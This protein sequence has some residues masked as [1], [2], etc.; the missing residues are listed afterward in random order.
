MMSSNRK[1]AISLLVIL[2]TLYSV[3][4]PAGGLG[5]QAAA[6]AETPGIQVAV[7]QAGYSKEDMKLGSVVSGRLLQDETFAVTAGGST[8]VFTGTL[9]Y[10]GLIWGGHVYTADFTGLKQTG[11][12]FRLVSGGVQ[13]PSFPIEDN[14][15]L[16]YRD[17]MTAFYRS[18]RASV[19]TADAL[20][21]GYT[22]TPLSPKAYHEAGHLDD[23]WDKNDVFAQYDITLLDGTRPAPGQHYD[24]TGGHYDAGDYGKYGGNQWVG[25]Q[26]ALAYLRY[27]EAEAVQFDY[28]D[29]GVPDILD[30]VRVAVEYT[31][32]FTDQ[33][34]GALFEIPE[35]GGF[36]HP[37]RM[38]DNIPLSPA[39]NSD[40]RTLGRLSIGGSAKAAG[41]MAAAARAY[42]AWLDEYG[43]ADAD[44]AAFAARAAAGA[45]KTYEYAYINHDK[46]HGG[47]HTGGDTTNPL[48]WAEVELYLLTGEQVYYDRAVQRI[49]VLE[50][51]DVGSTNYWSVRPIAMAE[52]Y[53]AADTATQSHIKRL[54]KSRV[55]Y[56]MS[57]AEDTPYGVLNEFSNFGVNEPHISYVGDLVRYYELFGDPEVLS[58]AKKGLF[59]VFGNNPW[60]TSWVSGVGENHVNYL[61]SRY[62]TEIRDPNNKGIVIPGAMV[63]GPNVK[64]PTVQTSVSGPWYEDR[65][66]IQDDVHQWRYN[67]FSISIQAGLFYSIMALG[68]LDEP[69]VPAAEEAELSILSPQIGDLVTGDVQVIAAAGPGVS[70]VKL[71][72]VAMT[73]SDG[74]WTASVNVDAARPYANGR[75]RATAAGSGGTT[76]SNSHYTVAPPLPSPQSPL[77]YDDFGGGGIWGA[78]NLAWMNWW[79]QDS[80][81]ANKTDGKFAKQTVDG[82]TVGVFTHEPSSPQALAKFQPWHYKAD[83][84]GYRYLYI[85]LKNS[86]RHPGLQFK[87]QINARDVNGS[88]MTVPNEWTTLQIDLNQVPNLDKSAVEL[89]FWLRGGARAGDVLIDNIQAGNE[90]S[91]SAPV[92]S[93]AEVHALTGDE[94]TVFHYSV[95]YTDADNDLPHDVQLVIDGVIHFMLEA[96][97]TD[98]DTSD[99]KRYILS[100]ALVRG[101]HQFYVRTTDTHTSVVQTPVQTGPVVAAAAP[102]AG[103]PAAP[104]NLRIVSATDASAVLEWTAPQDDRELTGYNIYQE[105]VLIGA[106]AKE[107]VRYEVTGLQQLT[108]YSFRVTAQGTA[109]ESAASNPV[110]LTTPETVLMPVRFLGQ[111]AVGANER[112]TAS[113]WPGSAQMTPQGWGKIWQSAQPMKWT[114]HFPETGVYDFSLRAYG[115]G[116]ATSARI[117]IDGQNVPDAAW[118]LGRAWTDYEGCLGTVTAGLHTV[119]IANTSTASNNNADIAHLDIFGAAPGAFALSAPADGAALEGTA[120]LLDWTQSIGGRAFA[121]F[122]ADEYT[123][124]VAGNE[125]FANPPV[126]AT[127]N[128]TTYEAGG[129]KSHTVYYWRVTAHNANRSTV[130]ETFSFT[131]AGAPGE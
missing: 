20:P 44:A 75:L 42:S 123:V 114:V 86:G 67:E 112:K 126:Q 72:D 93:G 103:V 46:E 82:R 16:Q 77:L 10:E 54:L 80:N 74:V 81:P 18:L 99:G 26:L 63:S 68:A 22:N 5:G 48:L 96:D 66:I 1:P 35:K 83:L 90:T 59:W 124:E 62:D 45:V 29:N 102:P 111:F 58:A 97:S 57:V 125:D 32:K 56:F 53:P 4:V 115:E 36:D 41:V 50:E 85:T 127:V 3:L 38:T 52:F 130:S 43:A 39:G 37:E 120:A 87:T 51:S 30:E 104:G 128:G 71:G 94:R 109:Q 13:S 31:L 92:L 129:L 95:T 78:Q 98:R 107:A 113:D 105:G 108:G 28:D 7:S 61:H 6:A 106:A 40:D 23:A 89:T 131:T 12:A 33:F 14:I 24:L 101:P 76:A 49:A 65:T 100:A 69:S 73:E 17:E 122:G 88:L 2:F 60:N 79:T 11:E 27:S 25:G 47:Y 70:G 118:T 91:G 8:P 117:R 64:D 119:E 19:A 15:W 110:S 55:D 84:S 121:P 34:D 21:D 116:T 9:K